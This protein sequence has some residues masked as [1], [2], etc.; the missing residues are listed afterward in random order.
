MT[1][2]GFARYLYKTRK[3]SHIYIHGEKRSRET[4]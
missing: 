3:W 4:L 2:F 1:C